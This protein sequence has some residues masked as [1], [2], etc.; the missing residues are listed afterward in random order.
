[1]TSTMAEADYGLLIIW[2]SKK[3]INNKI[4]IIIIIELEKGFKNVFTSSKSII[5]I[6]F[7]F[8]V[9]LSLN[10]P[11]RLFLKKYAIKT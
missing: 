10:H 5:I 8:F 4:I 6:I 2:N 9:N 11:T 3:L 7:V 1:M